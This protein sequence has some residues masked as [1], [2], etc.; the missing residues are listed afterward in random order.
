MSTPPKSDAHASPAIAPLRG[1]KVLEL[2]TMITGPLAGMMLGDLGAEVLKI[3]RPGGDPFRKY[4]D[5]LYSPQF[6]AFNRNKTSR[7]L[8]LKTREDR[9]VLRGLLR[10]HDVLIEN[11]RPGSLDALGMGADAL[12]E[13]NPRLIQCSI[14]G[15]GASG[16]YRDR[17]A[18]DGV[19]Q[20]LSGI[21]SLALDADEP[22]LVGTTISDN[23]TGM[24][25]CYAILAALYERRDTGLGRRLEVNMLESS[26]AFMPDAFLHHDMFGVTA[27]PLTRIASSC[28]FAFKCGDGRLL[29]IHLSSNEANWRGLARALGEPGLAEDPRYVERRGR[30][31]NY[32]ALRAQLAPLFA[33]RPRS[34][35]IDL[36]VDEDVPCAPVKT[37]PEVLEDEQILALDA[38]RAMP[39][40][41]G[42]TARLPHVPV[43]FDG[44]RAE[45]WAPPP[46]YPGER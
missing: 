27:G 19:G 36:L 11:M 38:F 15:F 7:I 44:A 23:V 42:M 31:A 35:W 24:Y 16:P 14:T 3:E 37:P 8:D 20:A 13:L 18:Y 9:D 39:L 4:N 26:V 33:R 46:A 28:A 45:A 2:A 1:V 17:P 6:V 12:R 22:A 29:A 40:A 34:E 21:A 32:R 30:A 10:D 5:T 43:L 25:A 41:N